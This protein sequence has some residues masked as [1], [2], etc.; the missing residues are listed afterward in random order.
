MLLFKTLIKY[1]LQRRYLFYRLKDLFLVNFK[2]FKYKYEKK[3][4]FDSE[5]DVIL[6]KI[7]SQFKLGFRLSDF[8]RK[9]SECE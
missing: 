9:I 6:K 5:V 1:P 4:K 7:S 3:I 8:C 2:S